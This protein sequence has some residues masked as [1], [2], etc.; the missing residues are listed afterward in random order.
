MSDAWSISPE[1][2]DGVL[3]SMKDPAEA[4]GVSVGL[5]Q[6]G[7][8]KLITATASAAIGEATSQYFVEEG[9]VTLAAISQHIQSGTNGVANATRA[10]VNGD[11]EMAAQ[12]QRDATAAAATKTTDLPSRGRVPLP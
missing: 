8:E 6:T 2:V 11:L 3:T 4:L 9:S 12:S 5:L 10:Y 1:G 7:L